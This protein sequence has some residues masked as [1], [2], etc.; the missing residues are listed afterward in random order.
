MCLF[1]LCQTIQALVNLNP[2]LVN[3]SGSCEASSASLILTQE[4]STMLNFTFTLVR[5]PPSSFQQHGFMY[6]CLRSHLLLFTEH[7]KQQV[8]PEWANAAG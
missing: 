8:P 1:V 3:S 7:H 5:P 2:K 4:Q 6:L